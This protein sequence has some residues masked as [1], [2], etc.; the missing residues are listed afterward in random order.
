MSY[1]TEMSGEQQ[2]VFVV[3]SS[4]SSPTAQT[5]NFGIALKMISSMI[6]KYKISP[7]DTQVGFVVYGSSAS[8][9]F[10]IGTHSD[11]TSL[12]NAVGG[13]RFPGSPGRVDV[14]INAGAT[15]LRGARKDGVPQRFVV[16]MDG[17]MQDG[18]SSILGDI[19]GANADVL[20]VG[21]GND[22]DEDQVGKMSSDMKGILVPDTD[23]LDDKVKD[24][25]RPVR[26]PG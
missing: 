2:I 5:K 20:F 16:F 23:D 22:V 10:S 8:P 25:A 1:F 6:G 11:K 9:A 21:I 13:I 26:K 4:S 15:M 17:D 3:G 18:A 24:L 12:L 14:G 7:S 19:K